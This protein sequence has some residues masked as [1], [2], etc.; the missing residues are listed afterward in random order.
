MA[1]VVSRL[2]VPMALEGAGN[3]GAR[4]MNSD[5][6]SVLSTGYSI[7]Q[8]RWTFFLFFTLIELPKNVLVHVEQPMLSNRTE[9][10][11]SNNQLEYHS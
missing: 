4:I 11:L 2:G 7:G 1:R 5:L 6:L 10:E 8:F 9:F 3:Q